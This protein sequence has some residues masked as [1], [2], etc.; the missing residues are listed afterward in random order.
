[1]RVGIY[2]NISFFDTIEKAHTTEIGIKKNDEI[3]TFRE[4][5]ALKNKALLSQG[6]E[7]K[8]S[9]I[10]SPDFVGKIPAIINEFSENYDFLIL[11]DQ[12]RKKKLQLR[13]F[14]IF[15]STIVLP[16]GDVPICQNL[17]LKLG[18]IHRQSLDAIL[19]SEETTE[20]QNWHSHNCNKCWI[21]YHRKYDVVLYR[22]FEKFFGRWTTKKVFGYYQWDEDNRKSYN[23]VMDPKKDP[24]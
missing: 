9:V 24:D 20:Q 19:Q 12:W 7:E 3:L 17:D 23:Q 8:T 13:C 6:K 22:T 4:A 11:Y 16:N 2:N 14:S 5:G 10:E 21:N 1:M 15:D 18:N